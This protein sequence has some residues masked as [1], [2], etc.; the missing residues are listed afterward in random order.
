MRSYMN[1]PSC[2]RFID[3][4]QI[5][6]NCQ[7]C[8][9][10]MCSRCMHVCQECGK[11]VCRDCWGGGN[12]CKQCNNLKHLTSGFGKVRAWETDGDGLIGI[13]KT[14]YGATMYLADGS[15]LK[16]KSNQRAREREEARRRIAGQQR[17]LLRED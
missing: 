8:G 13:G 3:I 4:E 12:M 17:K 15:K 11:E 5:E 10:D 16:E 2:G 1:C 7:L 9:A 14:L 6:A